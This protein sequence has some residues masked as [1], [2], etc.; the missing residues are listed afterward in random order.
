MS[1]CAKRG[2]DARAEATVA[3][4]YGEKEVVVTEAQGDPDPNL[5]RL[6]GPHADGLNPP[7][8]WSVS[9][10]RHATSRES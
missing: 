10:R 4:L 6:C 3:L 2:C 7:I 8:G 1:S 5:L 9:D